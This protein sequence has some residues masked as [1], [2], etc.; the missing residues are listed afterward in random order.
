MP[1]YTDNLQLPIPLG[2]E[3]NT[4]AALLSL[5]QKIDEAAASKVEAEKHEADYVKHPG[6]AVATN[7]GNAYAVTLTPAPTELVDGMA[8]AFKAP[9]ANTGAAT[10]NVNS[11]GAVALTVDGE[12]LEADT[13]K[14]GGIY[15][16]RYNA[17]T[18]NFTLQSKGGGLAAA[19]VASLRE[20]INTLI[21]M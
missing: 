18:T 2:N 5:I 9:A 4:R 11:L 17:T 20:D 10:L 12:A 1:T 7:V 6:Y 19:D 16:F 21:L 8:I 15:P 13:L 14:A 3:N